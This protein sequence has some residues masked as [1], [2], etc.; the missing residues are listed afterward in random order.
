MSGDEP[1]R[2]RHVKFTT[3]STDRLGKWA[4][5]ASDEDYDLVCVVILRVVDGTWRSQCHYYQDAVH[6][7]TWHIRVRDNLFLTVRFPQE[8]PSY[9]LLIYIGPL[10]DPGRLPPPA[11]IG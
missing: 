10:G 1:H 11:P 2:D 8:Y 5:S 4:E 6:P 3:T 7:L 9:A